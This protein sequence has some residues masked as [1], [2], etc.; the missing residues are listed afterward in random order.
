M[1]LG[2]PLTTSEAAALWTDL[3]A[4]PATSAELGLGAGWSPHRYL[5]ALQDYYAPADDHALGLAEWLARC[6]ITPSVT[7]RFPALES[8]SATLR[9]RG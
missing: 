7:G 5:R 1:D 8:S 6:T 9:G 3:H 2:S 4:R